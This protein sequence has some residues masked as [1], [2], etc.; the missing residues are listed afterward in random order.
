M[1]EF[2]FIS[3]YLKPL[4][5]KNKGSFNLNDDIFYD[6]KK[7]VAISVDTYVHGVHFLSTDPENFI[8]KSLRSSL[9]D[10]YCKGIKPSYYFLSI[11]LNK[12]IATSLWFNKLKK[13]LN[14]EQK[15]FDIYLGGGD[16]TYSSKFSITFVV[17]GKSKFKPILRIGCLAEDDIYVTGNI[18][19][20][21]IGLNVLKKKYNFKSLNSF[22][23]KKYYEPNL[24]TKI[25]S[26]LYKFASSSIDISDGLVQDLSHLTS[27]NKVGAFI[28][29]KKLP[30]SNN[31]KKL[32][33]INKIRIKDIF[34][35][36][37]DYQI[38]FTSK[39]KN[40]SKIINLSNHLNIKISRIGHIN[41]K[42]N[43]ILKFNDRKIMYKEEKMG[44]THNF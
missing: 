28:D 39:K 31:T 2:E 20:S 40:R 26:H 42:N 17:V 29:V 13:I 25:C 24:Q 16:T 19:D 35:K 14:S 11:S 21:L 18:G 27:L 10:L 23:V 44:Y 6:F 38:L 3:K 9:S 8:K 41:N 32:I 30:F 4:S 15:K 36:G 1:N 43:I 34:S 33:K 37:D 22:F 12:K 5:L 7:K